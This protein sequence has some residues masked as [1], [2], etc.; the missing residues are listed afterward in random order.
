M[1]MVHRQPA[2]HRATMLWHRYLLA[3]RQVSR[4]VA[5]RLGRYV[6]RLAV[7][8]HFATETTR[9]KPHINQ[10]VSGTYR[11]LVMLHDD[12]RVALIT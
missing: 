8:D 7:V 4:R 9:I 5:R 11:Q 12:D 3:P 2:L 1:H 6:A 10:V